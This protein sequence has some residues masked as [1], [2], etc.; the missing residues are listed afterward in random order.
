[1]GLSTKAGATLSS[2]PTSR[3]GRRKQMRSKHCAP[4]LT[5]SKASLARSGEKKEAAKGDLAVTSKDLRAYIEQ[6]AAL[7]PDCMTKAQD[8]EAVAMSSGEELKA[9]P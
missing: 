1:M 6:R 3:H 5:S 8:F 2:A 9:P 4:R 7:H